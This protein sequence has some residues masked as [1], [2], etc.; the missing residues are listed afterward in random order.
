M[1]GPAVV[2]TDAGGDAGRLLYC[3]G[4][5]Q[6][7]DRNDGGSDVIAQVEAA[8]AVGD[9]AGTAATAASGIDGRVCREASLPRFC[10]SCRSSAVLIWSFFSTGLASLD[11][12]L[13]AAEVSRTGTASFRKRADS[14]EVFTIMP[15]V[16]RRMLP[17]R[18]RGSVW[19]R[20]SWV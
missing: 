18:R 12:G 9:M 2:L 6:N 4:R 14:R 19:K 8:G 5:Y 20:P 11:G 16:V 15:A 3:S 13:A 17:L 1:Y 7:G 10:R